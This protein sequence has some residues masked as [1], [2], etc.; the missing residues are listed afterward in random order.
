[1]PA[2]RKRCQELHARLSNPRMCG[3]RKA[4]PITTRAP[5]GHVQIRKAKRAH[6]PTNQPKVFMPE[7]GGGG[8][9]LAMWRRY[10]Q[11]VIAQSAAS[12]AAMQPKYATTASVPSSRSIGSAGA[13]GPSTLGDPHD[14]SP[15]G[16]DCS[17]RRERRQ[18]LELAG[19]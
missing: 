9:N 8:P 4:P 1:M 15:G 14:D 3:A 19:C 16:E 5:S 11:R 18:L 10:D 13:L 17:K 12:T 2:S 6:Q 7:P